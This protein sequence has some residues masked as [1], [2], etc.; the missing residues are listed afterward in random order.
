MT[1]RPGGNWHDLGI[2]IRTFKTRDHH[3][4]KCGGLVHTV[5]CGGLVKYG[6]FQVPAFTFCFV[7]LL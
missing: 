7:Y 4:V 2:M 6:G 5:E 3:M 1:V